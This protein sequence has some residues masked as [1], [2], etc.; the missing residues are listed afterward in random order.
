MQARY[1]ARNP[2]ALR[3]LVASGTKVVGFPK[4][5]MEAA[6]QEAQALYSEL[7]ASNPSWKK[8]YEDYAAFRKEQNLWFRFAEAGFDDFMQ[9]AKL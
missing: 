5:V 4:V 2:A 6:F 9:R 3:S 1:D 8:I 7:S